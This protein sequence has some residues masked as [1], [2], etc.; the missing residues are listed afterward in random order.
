MYL[1]NR[2]RG[3]TIDEMMRLGLHL[4]KLRETEHP[5]FY[6]AAFNQANQICKN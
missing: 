5:F 1:D 3:Y 4:N 2:Y 6:F